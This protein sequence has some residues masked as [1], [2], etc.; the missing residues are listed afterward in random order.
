MKSTL[1]FA[2][3]AGLMLTTPAAAFDL[4]DMSADE[5]SAFRAEI[6]DYLL[7]NPEIIMEAVAVL[8]ARQA[9][10]QAA[11]DQSL[12]QNNAAALFDDPNSWVG[13]NPDGDVT[14]VEFIDYRCSYC[15]RAH[16]EVAQLLETDGNIRMVLKEFPILGADSVTSSRF[17]IATRQIAGDDAYKDVS[18]A[19]MTLKPSPG[20]PVLRQL[21]QSFDL[22]AEA[23]FERMDSESVSEVIAANHALAQRM[24]INGTPTFVVEDQ[25]LRGYVPLAGMIEIVDEVRDR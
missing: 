23:I 11:D 21:A 15:R 20:E 12:V 24:R 5:R 1:P 22:D 16:D 10:Q 2:L 17:A 14:I 3:I 25:M 4:T 9:E 7:E 19:L 8:E 13:G 6:R 18:D